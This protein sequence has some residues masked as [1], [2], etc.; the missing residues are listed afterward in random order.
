[1]R[2]LLPGVKVRF[3]LPRRHWVGMMPK[4]VEA[5]ARLQVS[6]R[7]S[8]LILAP[9]CDDETIGTGFLISEAVR[10]GCRF[11][12]A[13][14]TNGDAYVYAA[15][16]RYK[17][18]RLPPEKHIE[19]AYLRQ[20]ESLAALQ[21][22]KC[23]REDVVFLGYPD[24]GLMA[25]WREAWEPD[26]LYRSPFTR[27]DHSPYH[28]SYTSR[29][30]YC[31]RSVVDDIQKLIVSLK[32]SYLVVPHPRDAHGDHVATFCFAIYAWQ[33]LR[34]Q[35]YRHE[36][37]ILAYLVHRGTWPYPR[38]LHPGRTLAPPLSFYRLNENWLSLYPQNNA[39]TAKYRALQQ[40]KSQMSLQSRF[41]LS[42]VRKNELFCLYTPQRISGLV[43]PEHKS[44]LIGGNTADWSEKQALS[45]P[46]PVK[47]TITRNVEQGADVRTISVHADMGYIYLQLET[48]GRIAGDFVFTI[49]LVSCSKPRR[50]LQLRF[51]VPDKVYM[52]S[53][54]LWYATK[55]IVFKVRGK[56]LEMAVPRRHLAGAGCVFIYAET[57]RGRLMVDRTAWYVLFLPSSAGDSTVPVYA[58]AHRK[59]IPE[60]ATV[61][62]RAFLPEIRRVLDGRE[63]S[64]PMLTS[65]FEFLYTAEP[66]ALLVAKADGQVIGYI[67]APASLRHL[68]KTAFLRGYILRWVGYWLIGRYRFS[69]HA[70]RTILMDK[71]YFVHHA[72]KD[73]IEIDQRILSL[74]VLPERR[75]QG[76]AQELVRHA[77]ERFRTLGAEQVR[78]EVRPD[79]KPAL[80][81][82]RKAG[83]TVKKVIG[84]TRGEWLV[85]V[86][87]LRHEGD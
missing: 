75:G 22:L 10:C 71:L 41:L 87:N 84:D 46:E 56:Y 47:D 2:R 3:K 55:E 59:E 27:A 83:F 79:N 86:K 38:G 1:L 49:Q 35:G 74:G 28:N 9:H 6:H 44:I 43:G 81:L 25:M 82:Y 15:G 23:S 16:T 40:Y 50:S 45:F 54:H 77:L 53:G 58:T 62:C 66:G 85:M 61:F 37:K 73:D 8:F 11:R 20:K 69:F 26:H 13:V 4:A 52:K 67:Y 24:R 63:P 14:V 76:V 12:V 34:R 36:M 80:H 32:P 64:L 72:L 17:R 60:V 19:F 33:E 31:G 70:L 30:P 29:A 21:Q 42:F 48:N 51:I 57:G 7:D 65:L 39:I 78:L 68:W 18:L 5:G